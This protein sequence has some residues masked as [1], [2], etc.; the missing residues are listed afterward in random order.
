MEGISSAACAFSAGV[1]MITAASSAIDCM[2]NN[3]EYPQDFKPFHIG[4]IIVGIFQIFIALYHVYMLARGKGG[5]GGG[6]LGSGG[7]YSSYGGN[8]YY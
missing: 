1:V 6:S 7:G 8:N 3:E 5:G 2:N 4:V